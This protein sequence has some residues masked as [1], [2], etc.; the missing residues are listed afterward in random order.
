M[1]PYAVDAT[2]LEKFC[3]ASPLNVWAK[4]IPMQKVEEI[5]RLPNPRS[6]GGLY[7]GKWHYP[8]SNFQV[9][10]EIDDTA[11]TV[12]LLSYIRLP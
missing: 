7:R 1:I 10:A 11:R 8:V 5:R 9:V 12:R 4:S 3:A 2:S 6:R